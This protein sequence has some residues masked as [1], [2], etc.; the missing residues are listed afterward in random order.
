MTDI[1][2]SARREVAQIVDF[3]WRTATEDDVAAIVDRIYRDKIVVLKNQR[4][5]PSELVALG[6]RFGQPVSYYEPIY[7]HPEE[8]FV[9]VSSNIRHQGKQ[10]GVP[11]TGAFWHADYQFMPEPLAFTIFYPQRLPDG[12]RGTYFI[13]MAQAYDC[14]GPDLQAKVEGTV[15]HHSSRRYVK[16]RPEDVYRPIG[17]LIDEIEQKTPPQQFPTVMIH[18]VTGRKQ[19]YLSEAFTFKITDLDGTDLGDALLR[20]VLEQSGQL[21]PTFTDDKI[22]LHSYD[23]GDIVLWD[24]RALTHRALHNLSNSP[25]E[26][27]RVAVHDG[28]PLYRGQV[29]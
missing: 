13:D 12:C 29:R 3:D 22:F 2:H 10:V 7:H 19:L 14:L 21:D 27:Y 18:P 28:H 11:K 15:A 1:A 5:T 9:F 26:S 24:N 25:T 17:A 23:L 6:R 20:E 4:L 8:P 16:I